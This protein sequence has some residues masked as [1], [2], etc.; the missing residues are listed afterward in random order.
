V[1]SHDQ[2]SVSISEQS[3]VSISEES[4]VSTPY[5]SETSEA[6]WEA[7]DRGR[8][9]RGPGHSSVSESTLDPLDASESL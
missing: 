4:T 5:S 2:S 7:L 3:T 1:N 6:A 9:P 8:G